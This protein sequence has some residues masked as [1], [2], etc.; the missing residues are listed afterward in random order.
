MSRFCTIGMAAA[1]DAAADDAALPP[2]GHRNDCFDW[3]EPQPPI[4]SI[5]PGIGTIDNR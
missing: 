3:L 4:T 2:C 5:G 1:D